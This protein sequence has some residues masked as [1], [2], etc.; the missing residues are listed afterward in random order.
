MISI[1]DTRRENLILAN[2]IKEK[3]LE[4]ETIFFCDFQIRDTIMIIKKLYDMGFNI[5]SHTV[6]H[7]HLLTLDSK[8]QKYE[9]EES[10]KMIE[11]ITGIECN[12][13]AYPYGEYNDDIRLMVKRAG[14]K[15][16]RTCNSR[17]TGDYTFGSFIMNNQNWN[18][19]V[20]F[21]R[22]MYHIHMYNFEKYPDDFINF[23][24]FLEWYCEN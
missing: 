5:G 14:Y 3:K 9:I 23:N 6:N 4:K 15:H 16:A 12:W 19:A 10:K 17:E 21:K 2:M 11:N 8:R 13:F 18:K 24:K 22:P 20:A 1:D 7:Y